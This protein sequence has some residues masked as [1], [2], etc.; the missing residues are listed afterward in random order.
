MKE[1]EK[2]LNPEELDAQT[3]RLY[4]QLPPEEHRLIQGLYTFSQ[5]Y[6]RDNEH[7]LE[8]IWSRLVQK[9]QSAHLQRQQDGPESKMLSLKGNGMQ[10]NDSNWGIEASTLRSQ[11]AKQPGKGPRRSFKRLLG[12]G[13]GAVAVLALVL[14]WALVF[15]GA[16]TGAPSP[17]TAVGSSNPAAVAPHA[18]PL[19]LLCSFTAHTPQHL[20]YSP[21]H[22]LSW[23]S[24][25]TITATSVNLATYDVHTCKQTSSPITQAQIV[26]W[27]PDGTRMVVIVNAGTVQI[28]DAHGNVLTTHKLTSASATLSSTG[29]APMV[30]LSG[31][32]AAF[33][34]A[35]WS[36]D[37]T[38]VAS[39]Y[40]LDSGSGIEI[41]N[42]KTGA[43]QMTLSCPTDPAGKYGL[44]PIAT[45][46]PDGKYLIGDELSG[47]LTCIWN[48]HTGQR[49]AS[50]AAQTGAGK[51]FSPDGK[52]LVL[53][54]EDNN[55]M[56]YDLATKRIIHTFKVQDPSPVGAAWPNGVAWSPDGN[57]L[58]VVGRDL[59]LLKA[60]DGTEVATHALAKGTIVDALAWSP[61]S[62]M[63]ATVS[64]QPE[65]SLSDASGKIVQTP[66]NPDGV[67][68][69]WSAA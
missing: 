17:S 59:H 26:S 32:G 21:T 1:H 31:T 4:R 7:S 53:T 52:E 20:D 41:W 46:S 50:I 63:I 15:S 54:D 8:H 42:A 11:R 29:Y 65:T 19:K 58:A 34:S 35:T 38:Q 40:G 66:G 36:P 2:S 33:Y 61:D 69:I 18:N 68:N 64:Y 45:W 37:G 27:S 24:A 28:I 5:D 39:L 56:I 23:A 30:S 3:E 49:V 6:A 51:T 9:Q 14:S 55:V 43:H 62:T 12:L 10:T 25:S 60:S 47:N 13:I 48:A 16:R 44:P 57:F 22:N 67:V